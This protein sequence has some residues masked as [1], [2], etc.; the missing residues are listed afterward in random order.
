VYSRPKK[1]G[2]GYIAPLIA[3]R[4]R[5]IELG[6]DLRVRVGGLMLRRL[7]EDQHQGLPRKII[8]LHENERTW[9]FDARITAMMD[10]KQRELYNQALDAARA[11]T[12]ESPDLARL[13]IRWLLSCRRPQLLTARFL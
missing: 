1:V 10:G 11:E 13:Q 4:E 9:D 8:I 5:V 2:G 6:R 12:P 7:K 3:S